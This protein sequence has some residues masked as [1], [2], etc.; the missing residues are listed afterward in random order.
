VPA[1]RV[2]AA[3]TFLARRLLIIVLALERLATS[4]SQMDTTEW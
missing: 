4:S 3:P 2:G 1:S